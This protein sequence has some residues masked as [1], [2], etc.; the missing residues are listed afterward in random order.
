MRILLIGNFAPPY[1]DENLHNIAIL[2]RLKEEGSECT[3]INI[4]LSHSKEAGFIDAKSYFDFVFK[5]IRHAWGK[6][7]VHFF[8]KGYTRLGLL[9]LMT[10]IF[11]GRLFR[12]RAIVSLHSEFFSVIGQM[13]SKVGGQQTVYLSFSFAHKIIF[14]DKDTYEVASRYKRRHNFELIPL[15]IIRDKE[16]R[17]SEAPALKKLKDKKKIILFSNVQYPSLLFDILNSLISHTHANDIGIVISVSEIPSAKLQHL[18][19]EAGHDIS[20]NM[21]FVAYD[22]MKLL[23]KSYG[24]ADLTVRPMSCDGEI[25]FQDFAVYMRR[26]ERSENYVYFPSSLVL[27]K[28]GETADL[29]ACIISDILSKQDGE[30]HKLSSEDFYAK[31]RKIYEV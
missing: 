25:F 4:S 20:G 14:E 29:C 9:K 15:F 28:E 2:K 21:V 19:E 23:L 26:T 13:R 22:D 11:I 12:A 31:L 10:S 16:T 27:V 18:L 6:D 8:T 3:V 30:P 5:V 24:F 1:E 7:V 17:E